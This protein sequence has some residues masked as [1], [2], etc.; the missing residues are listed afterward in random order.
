MIVTIFDWD[1]TLMCTSHILNREGNSGDNSE[2]NSQTTLEKYEKISHNICELISIA[3]AH[4]TVFIVTNASLR[5][6]HECI[7]KNLTPEVEEMMKSVG[8]FSTVDSGIAEKYDFPDRKK[9]AFAKLNGLFNKR[10][11]TK[12]TLLCIGDCNHDRDAANHT[13]EKIR[14][15][16]Y[17]KNIKFIQAPSLDILISQQNLCISIL[18][19]LY[20]SEVHMDHFLS[21]VSPNIKDFI[22]SDIIITRNYM[23]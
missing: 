7:F 17:V 4:G 19:S 2:G 13:R 10:N 16:T 1:D 8:I 23:A 22:Q 5:W 12:H 20:T 15:S 21:P 3:K 18:P 11:N 6:V 9:I 14:D